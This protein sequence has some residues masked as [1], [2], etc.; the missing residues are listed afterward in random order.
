VVINASSNPLRKLLHLLPNVIVTIRALA[1][2]RCI[3]IKKYLLLLLQPSSYVADIARMTMKL[4]LPEKSKPIYD[5]G[6]VSLP[7]MVKN[8]LLR[9]P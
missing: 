9:H 7:I 5:E 1:S 3:E 4:L 8:A 2:L 6:I